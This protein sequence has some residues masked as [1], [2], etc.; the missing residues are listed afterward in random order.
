MR[1]WILA[2]MSGGLCVNCSD[3][4]AGEAWGN[5]EEQSF[6]VRAVQAAES[7]LGLV[8]VKSYRRICRG[9]IKTVHKP[10][11]TFQ[12][13]KTVSSGSNSEGFIAS[14]PGWHMP[15]GCFKTGV[16]EIY[17]HLIPQK[18]FS[19]PPDD[20]RQNWRDVLFDVSAS[21]KFDF[22]SSGVN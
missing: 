2:V 11:T 3:A 18:P 17:L 19:Q 20:T 9:C 14:F 1:S 6:S 21:L 12:P 5:E 15:L 8:C 22:I 13:R 7:F 10:V 4:F 16:L